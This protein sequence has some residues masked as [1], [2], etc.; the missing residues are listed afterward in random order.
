MAMN[1][2]T[3]ALQTRTSPQTNILLH[4]VPNIPVS[5]E[6]GCGTDARMGNI[7]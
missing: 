2:R 6:L 3:L 7:V 5:D 4:T 1:F